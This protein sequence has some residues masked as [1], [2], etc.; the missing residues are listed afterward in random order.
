M[1]EKSFR[2]TGAAILCAIVLTVTAIGC[3]TKHASTPISFEQGGWDSL[4]YAELNQLIADNAH[5]GNYAVFDFD[6]TTIA[7]DI[8]N[9]VMIYQIE[10]LRFGDAVQCAFS[11]GIPEMKEPLNG[12]EISAAEMGLDIKKDYRQMQAMMD[13]GMTLEE[14]QQTDVYLDYRARF[15]SF[16]DALNQTFPVDVW[17]AWMPG[18][19]GGFTREEAKAVIRDALY[20][21]YG[22]EKVCV[23]E[24]RSP[25]GRW[26]GKVERGVYLPDEIRNLYRALD[27]NE[28]DA[29]VC[30]ASSELIVETFA[31]D[32]VLGLGL[33][34][35]RVFGLRFEDADTV[36]ADYEKDYPQS[37]F[38][39]KVQCIRTC[40]A[41][42]Y[43]GRDPVLVAGDS[44]GDVAMLTNFAGMQRGLL[45]DVGRNPES[46]IGLLVTKA[47][48]EGSHGRYLL[49]PSF[50]KPQ[51]H[52][53]GGGI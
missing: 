16:L 11:N 18:L 9:A 28:I 2:H 33:P 44:N 31:C 13:R 21:H 3:Q 35:D 15:I 32:S 45:I 10:H 47:R 50:V 19:L 43:D 48:S 52:T 23:E 39:G 36:T 14:V 27:E 24:W 5:K 1:K 46:A 4:V 38:A 22:K 17:Y 34:E 49:Q 8:S 25:D 7:H 53:A 30:S 41:P 51:I 37:M 42:Q 6:K 12:I 20:E 29:Y 26:G 40:I